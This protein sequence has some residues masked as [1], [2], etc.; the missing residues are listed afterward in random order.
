[1][2]QFLPVRVDIR[3]QQGLVRISGEPGRLHNHYPLAGTIDGSAWRWPAATDW[4]CGFNDLIAWGRAL[5]G[6]FDKTGYIENR[7]TAYFMK[8]T[9]D[10]RLE[11]EVKETL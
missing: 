7:K 8:K 5:S 2:E 10:Y 3:E 9:T 4:T 1:L 6:I 11:G